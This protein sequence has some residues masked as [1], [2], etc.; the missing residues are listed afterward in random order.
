MIR[1]TSLAT[2][3]LIGGVVVVIVG[4]LAGATILRIFGGLLNDSVFGP[5]LVIGLVTAI[6][7]WWRSR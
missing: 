3:V 6:T 4:V 1:Y 7:I 2:I 5:I